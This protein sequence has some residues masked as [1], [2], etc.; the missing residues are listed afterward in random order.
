MSERC[1]HSIV[2]CLC[3]WDMC[4]SGSQKCEHGTDLVDKLKSCRTLYSGVHLSFEFLFV[5]CWWRHATAKS[6]V[7]SLANVRLHSSWCFI[8]YSYWIPRSVSMAQTSWTEELPNLGF[9]SPT[10]FRILVSG[11][12]PKGASIRQHNACVFG[13]CVAPD[14]KKCEH[15]TVRQAGGGGFGMGDPD[16]F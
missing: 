5:T 6:Y 15:G 14:P 1:K 8:P 4:G 2:H 12:R 3:L 16:H 11:L 7:V 10:E 9:S 13:K